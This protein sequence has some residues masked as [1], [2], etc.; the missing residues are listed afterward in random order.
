MKI[1]DA[2]IHAFCTEGYHACE[3]AFVNVYRMATII[4]LFT[5]L[6]VYFYCI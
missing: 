1:L 5:H 6:L 3:C 2:K 4:V